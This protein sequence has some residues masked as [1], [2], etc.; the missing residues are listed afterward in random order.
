MLKSELI[1]EI[2]QK[3][4]SLS[5]SDTEK[6]IDLFFN[7]ISNGLYE[8]YNIESQ[9]EILDIKTIDDYGIDPKMKESLLIALLG[10]AR[11][12]NM[13]ANMPSVTGSH[14]EIVLGDIYS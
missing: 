8:N 4:K 13:P 6:I 10:V 1:L 5:L 2:N 3:Y 9:I 7:K 12:Q 14:D 11:I